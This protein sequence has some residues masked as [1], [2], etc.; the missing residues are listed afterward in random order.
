MAL[1]LEALRRQVF[2]MARARMDRV[3][4]ITGLA[5]EVVMVV[6]G[7]A[8]SQLARRFIPR[9]LPGQIDAHDFPAIKQIFQL[10]VDRGLAQ[11]GHRA[12]R[13]FADFLRHQ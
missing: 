13:Q 2:H 3:N 8:V 4:A 11:P 6:M 9:G 7:V 10:P 12:L 1:D 5:M